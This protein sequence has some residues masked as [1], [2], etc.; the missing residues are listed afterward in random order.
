MVVATALTIVLVVGVLLA[1]RFTASEREEKLHYDRNETEVVVSNLTAA[2]LRLFQ[3]GKSL[4][5]A[6][7]I[8]SFDGKRIWLSQGNYL[9]RVDLPGFGLFYPV[10]IVGYRSGPDAK[11]AFSVTVRPLPPGSPPRLLSNLPDLVYIPSGHFLLGDRLNPREPH[12]VWLSGFFVSPFEVTNAEFR[13]FLRDPKGYEEGSNWTEKG[14]NWKSVSPSRT[15]AL[16][17]PDDAEFSRFGQPDQPLVGVNWFEANAYCQ[18][19]TQ[20]LGQGKW[21][22]ALPTEAEWEKAARGP[23]NF[24]Y[25]LGMSLSDDQVRSYNWKKNPGAAA[26][27]VGIE[28]SKSIYVPNRYGLYHMSGNVSEWTKSMNR[29]YNGEHPYLEGERN[30]LDLVGLRIVRGGSW[31]SASI[32][33]LSISY[34]ETFQ[35]EVS[36]PYLGFRIVAKRI[37]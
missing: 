10:P 1:W 35:P 13:E 20:T 29:P 23:D 24:D 15:T 18:W 8:V 31:Y 19:L 27:V 7:E 37:G 3:A 36:T 5:D 30:S 17:K 32:A 28:V 14:K 22:F 34:R 12:Y 9:L 33:T 25:G 26:T 2:P 4:Q 11:G 16:L 6:T 21:L